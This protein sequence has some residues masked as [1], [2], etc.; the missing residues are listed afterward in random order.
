[1]KICSIKN[2]YEKHYG[3]GFCSRHLNQVKHQKELMDYVE[4]VI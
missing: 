2:C 1:M 4:N 3:K